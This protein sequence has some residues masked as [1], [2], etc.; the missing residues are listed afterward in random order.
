MTS[1][2]K[3]L[4]SIQA[5]VQGITLAELLT[6]SPNIA[7]RTSQRQI[8]KLIEGGQIIARGEGRARRYFGV[9]VSE[10]ASL[11]LVP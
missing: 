10:K 2:S 7:R 11:R 6:Q 3:L 5:S 9:T 4:V 1:G 8:A